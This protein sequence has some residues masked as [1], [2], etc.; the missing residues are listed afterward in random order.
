[1]TLLFKTPDRVADSVGLLISMLVRYPE[2]GTVN[3]DPDQ[4]CLKLTFIVAGTYSDKDIETLSAK[5]M[6]SIQAYQQLAGLKPVIFNIDWHNGDRCLVLEL[7]RDVDTLSLEELS[8]LMEL[9]AIHF[10][11]ALI[12]ENGEDVFEDDLIMQEEIIIHMLDN[13]RK[14]MPDKKLIA[15]REE[16]KVLVFNR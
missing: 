4:R 2:I 1:M 12:A 8:F 10:N 14:S 3:F 13:M 16:G 9:F 15:Y 5:L 11:H 6:D 7:K